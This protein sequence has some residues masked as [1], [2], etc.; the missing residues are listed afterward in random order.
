MKIKQTKIESFIDTNILVYGVDL[1]LNNRSFHRASLEIL[2][3]NEQE[4]LY[5]SPQILGEFYSVIT[6]ANAVQ[7]PSSPIEAFYR[8]KRLC[9][10]PNIKVLSV[11]NNVQEKWLEL[12]EIRPV[13]GGQVFDLLHLATMLTNNIKRIYTFN[14]SDFNWYKDIEVIIPN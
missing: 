7:N 1:S 9:Q 13:K 10:M 14:E 11:N 3:P 4:I 8:I 2:R 6:S 12:L 5:L